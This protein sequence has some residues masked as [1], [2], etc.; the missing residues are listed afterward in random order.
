MR[1]TGMHHMSFITKDIKVTHQFFT[2]ILGFKLVGAVVEDGFLDGQ[3]GQHLRA[4]YALA[5]S[6]TI[7]FIEFKEEWPEKLAPQFKYRHYAFEVEGEEA[8]EYWKE[9]LKQKG[10]KYFGP[11]NHEDVFHSVYFFDPNFIFMEI[12]RHAQTLG[13]E[14]EAE[15]YK[16]WQHYTE[17]YAGQPTL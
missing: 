15:A 3:E 4:S 17:K 9:R 16:Q 1:I 8:F 5:D 2:E 6:S 14:L 10:V 11:I 13:P 7:D 12:T